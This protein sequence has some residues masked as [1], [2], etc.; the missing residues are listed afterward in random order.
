[1]VDTEDEEARETLVGEAEYEEEGE[2]GWDAW[3]GDA[4]GLDCV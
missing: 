2:E 4:G 3:D 1:M